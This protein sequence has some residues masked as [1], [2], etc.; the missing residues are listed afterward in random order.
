MLESAQ[1]QEERSQAL[2]AIYDFI[3]VFLISRRHQHGTD[4]VFSRHSRI[5]LLVDVFES[6]SL[7]VGRSLSRGAG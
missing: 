3:M 7:C 6:V 2:L 5:D 4:E 1:Q